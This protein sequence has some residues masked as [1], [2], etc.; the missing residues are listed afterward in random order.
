MNSL[1]LGVHLFSFLSVDIVTELWAWFH[2]AT[3]ANLYQLT[4]YQTNSVRLSPQAN[5]TD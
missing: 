2:E 4:S 3:E 5:Y 1:I